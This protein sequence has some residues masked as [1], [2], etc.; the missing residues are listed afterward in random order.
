[1]QTLYRADSHLDEGLHELADGALG[2]WTCTQ[3]KNLNV[4][5]PYMSVKT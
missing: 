4:H 1:M 5:H 3:F 2:K